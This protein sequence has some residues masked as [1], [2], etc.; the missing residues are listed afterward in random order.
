MSLPPPLTAVASPLGWPAAPAAA[1]ALDRLPKLTVVTPSYNQGH[2]LEATMRSVL[3]QDYP[4]LEYMV[5][6]G[7]STDRSREIIEHYAGHLAY[8]V[9]EKDLGQSDAIHKGLDRATGEWF[10]WINSDDLLAPGALWT[11]AAHAD[12]H[13]VIAGVTQYFS[14]AATLHRQPSRKFSA[15]N[16]IRHQL[17]SGMK[18]HQPSV[19]LRTQPMQKIGLNR[20]LHY[21]FDYE[22][23]VR[24]LHRYPRVMHL[25]DVLAWFRY[26]DSS[27]TVRQGL[28]FRTDQ[29][30]S[31]RAMS[32]EP[33]FSAL[34]ADLDLAARSVQWLHEVDLMLDDRAS[35]RLP[36]FLHLCRLIAQDRAA[37]CTGNTRRAAL[38]ILKYG[39]RKEGL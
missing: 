35:P 11:V 23:M 31:Y 39:G 37:R 12:E 15:R 2:Y 7:G 28:R 32:G 5:I 3:G 20:K 26:H 36:R 6:D 9:S 18:W 4:N 27:K 8:W 38:R 14:D 17:G 33:E 19:W 13:D 22:L 10:V 24:Y 1:L 21:C 34:R 30:A 25:D 29:V 16:F